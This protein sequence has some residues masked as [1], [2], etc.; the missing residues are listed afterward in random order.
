MARLHLLHFLRSSFSACALRYIN[1]FLFWLWR[2]LS[3]CLIV[4]LV[5]GQ[6]HHHLLELFEVDLAVAVLVNFTNYLFPD[7]SV[8]VEV[9]TKTLGDFSRFNGAPTILVEQVERSSQI[10]FIHQLILLD[11][12]CAPLIEVYGS[13][14]VPISYLKDLKCALVDNFDGLVRVQSPV[15]S[16]KFVLLDQPVA[17]LIEL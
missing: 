12:C 3:G 10:W 13:A 14:A 7:F 1:G 16:Q 5:V 2:I 9:I 17:V 6:L 4:N 8:L 15:A 11:R